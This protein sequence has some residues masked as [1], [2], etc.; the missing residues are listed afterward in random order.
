[1]KKVR[2]EKRLNC[3]EVA[4]ELQIPYKKYMMLEDGTADVSCKI[5]VELAD[6]FGVNIQKLTEIDKRSDLKTIFEEKNM[7]KD[8]IR[9]VI[10]IEQILRVFNA[11]EKLYYQ[12]NQKL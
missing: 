6:V 4:K 1:M 7:G 5:L 10:A 11:H 9:S 12:N 2:R 3:E 8:I